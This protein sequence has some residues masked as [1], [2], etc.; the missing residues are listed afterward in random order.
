M[1]SEMAYVIETI[2]KAVVIIALFASLAGFATYVERKLLAF[3]QRR[4]GPMMVGPYGVLQLVADMVK[5]FTKEDIVPQNVVKPIFL[6]APLIAAIAA[7]T[8]L[9]GVPFFP[10][11]TLF[12]HTVRPI[13][14]DV[15]VGVLFVMGV[16]SVSMYA[17]LLGGM[18]SNNKW[19][20]LGS[21][22]AVIQLLSFEVV[23]EIGR[24][25]V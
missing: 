7:M 11:F 2:I 12:G 19:G 9:A 18:A 6:I 10:E 4:L 1:A 20:L 14:A 3:F 24:A 17:P 23:S 5:L 15:G 22:R 13:L 8:A 25:H 16:A 21:A